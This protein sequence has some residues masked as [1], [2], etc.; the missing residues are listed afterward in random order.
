MTRRQD[1]GKTPGEAFLRGIVRISLSLDDPHVEMET[2]TGTDKF[3]SSSHREF[4][5]KLA[6]SHPDDL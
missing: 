3:E 4:V 5:P 2:R 6:A 1:F